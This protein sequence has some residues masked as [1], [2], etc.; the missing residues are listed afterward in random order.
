MMTSSTIRVDKDY[1]VTAGWSRVRWGAVFA[2][3]L[4]T[5][6]T[7]M[8]LALLGLAI[9]FTAVDPREG[10]P[11]TGLG[12]GAAIWGA[13]SLVVSLF[14]GAWLAGRVSGVL[15]R[16]DG[17]LNGVLVWA[18]SLVAMVYFVSTG[19]TSLVGNLFG[20]VGGTAQVAGTAAGQSAGRGED[21]VR[22]ARQAA[23]DAGV[24][25]DRVER[26]ARQ[27]VEQARQTAREIG[28]SGTPANQEAR[29]AAAKATGYAAT[30]A[31]SLLVAALLGLGVSAF[32]GASGAGPDRA[33]TAR[34]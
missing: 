20:A 13:L 32:G 24:D 27:A 30:G 4:I 25:V 33:R 1:D 7:Q 26:Q 8:L 31:W 29:E 12:W 19:V 3:V 6:V 14:L 21:P 23:R 2:G 17:A 10:A 15:R 34:V 22:R 9:G 18:V 5:I 28:Q 11:G 16:A